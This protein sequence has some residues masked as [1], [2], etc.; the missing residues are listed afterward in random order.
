[1]I[2]NKEVF[3]DKI[4]DTHHKVNR[5]D[6]HYLEIEGEV[7]RRLRKSVC[8]HSPLSSMTEVTKSFV[9]WRLETGKNWSKEDV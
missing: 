7:V 9:R 8:S 4:K 2:N 5:V 1:M 3:W 6:S